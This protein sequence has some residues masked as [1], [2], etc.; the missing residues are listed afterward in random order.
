MTE[1]IVMYI[2]FIIF[3]GSHMYPWVH[4]SIYM[5]PAQQGIRKYIPTKNYKYANMFVDRYT[6][7][8]GFNVTGHWVIV[9]L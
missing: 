7:Y 4:I 2:I 1:E 6:V 3:K 5:Y 9:L 8:G